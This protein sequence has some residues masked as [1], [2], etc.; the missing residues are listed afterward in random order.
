MNPRIP[1][2]QYE[3]M[4][5]GHPPMNLK[6]FDGLIGRG[7]AVVH[8]TSIKVSVEFGEVICAGQPVNMGPF[9]QKIHLL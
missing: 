3:S 7:S 9:K 5:H 6:G 1:G 8:Q 4:A 2:P